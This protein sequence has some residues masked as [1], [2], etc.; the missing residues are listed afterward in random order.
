MIPSKID[1]KSLVLGTVLGA[2]LIITLGA[3]AAAKQRAQIV[4]AGPG[5]GRFAIATNAGHAFVLDTATGRVWEK[6]TP[7]GGGETSPDFTAAKTNQDAEAD[8][9]PRDRRRPGSDEEEY[10]EV[11][12]AA[13]EP[14]PEIAPVPDADPATPATAQTAPESKR[15][16][17]R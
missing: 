16:P 12:P 1:I 14:A 2:L 10:E 7:A 6:F 8:T 15:A 5:P 11:P 17:G 3:G 9:A 4:P 13:V